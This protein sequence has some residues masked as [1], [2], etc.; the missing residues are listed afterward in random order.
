[1]T[2]GVYHPDRYPRRR[3]ERM[4]VRL[5]GRVTLASSEDLPC[6]TTTVSAGGLSL[7]TPARLA[8]GDQVV[9]HLE[10][11]GR[12]EAQVVGL[13]EDGLSL[14]FLAEGDARFEL[15]RKIDWIERHELGEVEDARHPPRHVA[16]ENT[17]RVRFEDGAADEVRLLD[18]SISG[19]AVSAARRP[20]L[21]SSIWM[22]PM[23][24]RVVRHTAAGFA[25]AFE[26]P[27]PEAAE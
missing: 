1:M 25:V 19:A 22:G 12:V 21:G 9:C 17:I 24:G 5:V 15:L 10:Q 8:V 7:E 26:A 3:D 2:D 14:A 6:A 27:V 4:Q 18:V 23:R 16:P 20:P 13:H 11:L